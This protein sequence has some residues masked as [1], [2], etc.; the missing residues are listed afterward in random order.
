MN[1]LYP[2]LAAVLSFVALSLQLS[3]GSKHERL[4]C[5]PAADLCREDDQGILVRVQ[6]PQYSRPATREGELPPHEGRG[7]EA[8][9]VRRRH[10]D[11]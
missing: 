3:K 2:V 5:K 8:S 10:I 1:S 11:E 7:T 9:M 4:L 6:Q